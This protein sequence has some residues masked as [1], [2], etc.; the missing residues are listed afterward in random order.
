[1]GYEIL[2]DYNNDLYLW[3]T[4]TDRIEVKITTFEGLLWYIETKHNTK[5]D[6]EGLTNWK[7]SFKNPIPFKDFFG[8]MRTISV[9]EI[10]KHGQKVM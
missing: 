9:A 10:K 3:N 5:L 1:M 6:D 7:N 8:E 4:V 2:K